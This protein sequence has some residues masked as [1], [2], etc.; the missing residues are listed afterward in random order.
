[1]FFLPTYPVVGLAFLMHLRSVDAIASEF[2]AACTDIRILDHTG[3]M[4]ALCLPKN[5]TVA[6]ETIFDLNDCTGVSND[7]ELELGVFTLLSRSPGKFDFTRGCQDVSIVNDTL[8]QANCSDARGM[9]KINLVALDNCIR[10]DDNGKLVGCGKKIFHPSA[11]DPV[12]GFMGLCQD[13]KLY[14]DTGI[15][16]AN[17]TDNYGNQY[18]SVVDLN[19]CYGTNPYGR[20]EYGVISNDATD[21]TDTCTSLALRGNQTLT[22]SCASRKGGKVKSEIDLGL[23]TNVSAAQMG[24]FAAAVVSDSMVIDAYWV[25]VEATPHRRLTYRGAFRY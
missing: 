24:N 12:G 23:Q 11:E 3:A 16:A 1:M 17:C 8:L 18:A 21:F 13:L 22:C 20:L 9:F 14:N 6:V 4:A 19:Q 7:G 5:K 2:P 10:I 15:L 25:G